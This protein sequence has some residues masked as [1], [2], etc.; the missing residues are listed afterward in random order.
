MEKKLELIEARSLGKEPNRAETQTL[1]E[2]TP[3]K[4]SGPLKG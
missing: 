4:V 2:R 3:L 1:E